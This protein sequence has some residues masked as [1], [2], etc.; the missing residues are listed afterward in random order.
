MKI[1]QLIVQ[2][3]YDNKKVTLQDIGTFMLSPEIFITPDSDKI[4]ELPP[5]AITFEHN[6]KAL[7]DE[8]LINFVV[9]HTR[10]IK[11][12]ATAD[13]ESYCILNKQ[14]LNIGKPFIIEG[15]GTLLKNQFGQYEFIQS[16]IS[17]PRLKET[18]S[19]VK[20]K[21][22]EDINF[23]TAQKDQSS[24][25]RFA[26]LLVVVLVLL[27]A[28][29]LYYF[30][31]KPAKDNTLEKVEEP[32]SVISQPT[33]T[34]VTNDS[35]KPVK[36]DTAAV[37]PVA[38]D[39]NFKIVIKEYPNIIA[40]QKAYKRLTG[41]GHTL[42]LTTKDS[43]HYELAIPFNTALTDT[44]RAKDSLSIFFNTKAFIDLN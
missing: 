38:K 18:P 14:F 34:P 20:E 5:N 1:E 26:V 22:Y 37:K 7:K 27:I 24:K 31:H 4:A 8:G 19:I 29:A 10:K 41:Y 23:T 43:S 21:E 33:Q 9:E 16:T 39:Y 11:P 13:L 28:A 15:L 30:L 3:L 17:N 6:D 42:I 25:K 36:P 32:I 35:T 12:L 40:A 2:Y 44:L